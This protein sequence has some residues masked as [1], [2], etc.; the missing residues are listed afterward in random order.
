MLKS[1]HS[2]LYYYSP[3]ASN[4][5]YTLVLAVMERH[6]IRD[7]DVNLMV[8]PFQLT[9]LIHDV[10]YACEKLGHFT[11]LASYTL[12]SATAILSNFFWNIYDRS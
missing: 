5:P 9:S 1:I 2:V 6:G 12:E 4:I 11:K 7:G 10:Y 3:T 8:P